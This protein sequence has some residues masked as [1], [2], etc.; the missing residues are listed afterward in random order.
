MPTIRKDSL[1]KG[2]LIL[3][4]AAFIARF[5]GLVQRVPLQRYLEDYG[6]ALYGISYNIYFALLIV[7]TAGIPSALSK[8]VA[9]R[10]ALGKEHEAEQIYAAAA[11]FAIVAG[12]FMTLL[13]YFTA[14]Y[15]ATY[16][17]HVPESAQAIRALAPALLLFPLI[18]MMRGYFQGRQNMSAG[19]LSQIVE[20]ILRV[21]TAVLLVYFLVRFGFSTETAAAGA[22]FGGVAGSLGAFLV[23]LYF[24]RKTKTVPVQQPSVPEP[25]PIALSKRLIYGQIFRLALPISVISIIVPAFYFIDSSIVVPLIKGQLAGGLREAQ[26]VLGILVGRAQSFAGIPPIL[27]IALSTSIIPVISAA[28]AK[29]DGAEV[30]KQASLA[31]RLALLAGLPV[32]IM[33][34]VSARAY[35]EFLFADAKGTWI[36]IALTGSAL[37]QVLMMTSGAILM[38]LGRTRGPMYFVLFGVL[39]KLAISVALAPWFGIYGIIA[40]TAIAFLFILLMNLRDLR[41]DVPF[42]ILGRRWP[43]LL[44][45]TLAMLAVGLFADRVLLAAAWPSWLAALSCSALLGLLYPYLLAVSGVFRRSD[46]AL[47]P[48]RLQ[49]LVQR[50]KWIPFRNEKF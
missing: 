25:E 1:I 49:A 36:I 17:A 5:L 11:R 19:G 18:A 50:L 4:A 15:Y 47:L 37:F 44:L 45:S 22:A 42:V 27:A 2:T 26:E 40:A 30:S 23:M 38:G 6:M 41:R 39:L 33:L 7:A 29:G 3:A 10:L 8:L 24:W 31:L 46:I 48:L 13:L 34:I 43:G 20:Q 35:N 12:V 21:V 32:V 14:P 28:Y 16:V 9:D